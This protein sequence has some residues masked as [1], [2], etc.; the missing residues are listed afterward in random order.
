MWEVEGLGW[1]GGRAHRGSEIC[2]GYFKKGAMG[3]M[4][5]KWEDHP[6]HTRGTDHRVG[7]PCAGD[8]GQEAGRGYEC[9]LRSRTDLLGAQLRLLLANLPRSHILHQQR[10]EGEDNNGAY[11]LG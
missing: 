9:A 3:Q 8:G 10:D 6:L 4:E 1:N 5:R 7:A 11:L 2:V